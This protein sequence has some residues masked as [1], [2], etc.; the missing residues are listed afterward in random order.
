VPDYHPDRSAIIIKMHH[1]FTD[2]L[3]FSA[4]MLAISGEYSADSLPAL[5]PFP[6]WTRILVWLSY[7]YILMKGFFK[8]SMSRPEFNSIRAGRPFTGKI[9]GATKDL[10]MVRVKAFCKE[11]SC[12][13]NEF[14]TALLSQ[15]IHE[16]MTKHPTV[17]GK[18]L[19]V[20]DQIRIANAYSLR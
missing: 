12:T 14:T 16:Y 17:D 9:N 1:S 2:G 19:A 4:F 8:I 18:D 15:T 6:L 7:P 13:I 10:D 20:P 3:G 11:Q 5:K